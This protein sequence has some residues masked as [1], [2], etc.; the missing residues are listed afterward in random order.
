MKTSQWLVFG[1]GTFLLSMFLWI[2]AFGWQCSPLGGAQLYTACVIKQQ[3]YAI[4]AIITTTFAVIFLF[5]GALEKK[6]K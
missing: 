4:P 5:C 3:S 1:I 6:N 2:L